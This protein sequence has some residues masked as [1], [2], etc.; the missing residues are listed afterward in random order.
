MSTMSQG[1]R[2]SR[3]QPVLL[4]ARPHECG[5]YSIQLCNALDLNTKYVYP[6][7]P[8]MLLEDELHRETRAS[9]VYSRLHRG[10]VETR[11]PLL[12]RTTTGS[13]SR[14]CYELRSLLPLG[15]TPLG[16]L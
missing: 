5:Y 9:G 8:I 4:P 12:G 2:D 7:H 16:V 1:S 3:A 14:A 15:G 11:S 10:L 6:F 13:K